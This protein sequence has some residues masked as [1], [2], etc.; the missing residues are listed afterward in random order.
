M[1]SISEVTVPTAGPF[2]RL[3]SIVRGQPSQA[4]PTRHIVRSTIALLV[5][6]SADN[7]MR[8]WFMQTGKYL[9]MGVL[10][11]HEA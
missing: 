1:A 4:S 6:G 2:G 5:S 9:F 8:L 3:M 10:Y 7:E 11:G